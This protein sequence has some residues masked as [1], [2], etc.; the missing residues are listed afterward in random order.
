MKA[1]G[2]RALIQWWS[3]WIRAAYRANC[4]GMP[5]LEAMLAWGARRVMRVAYPLA[6][7]LDRNA[8]TTQM[9]EEGWW[10]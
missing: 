9:I 2:A 3:R 10:G 1:A 8:A 5:R 7:R 6:L 4:A